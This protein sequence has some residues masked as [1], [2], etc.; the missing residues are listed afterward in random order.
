MEEV[1]KDEE[2]QKNKLQNLKEMRKKVQNERLEKLKKLKL[3]S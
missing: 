3:L 2:I 1:I